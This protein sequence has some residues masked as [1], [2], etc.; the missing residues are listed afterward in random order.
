MTKQNYDEDLIEKIDEI[1]L[2]E[3]RPMSIKEITSQLNKIYSIKKS[4]QI[5]LRHLKILKDR[6]RI[7]ELKDGS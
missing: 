3:S 4:P 1:L 6:K 2:Y 7:K 5:V